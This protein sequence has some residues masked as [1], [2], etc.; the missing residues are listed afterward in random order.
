MADFAGFDMPIQYSGIVAEHRAVRSTAGIFDVSHMGEFR[1]RGIE[2]L[3]FLQTVL[4]NDLSRLVDGGAL[5]TVMCTEKGGIVDDL[6]VYRV[7]PDDYLLVVNAAN[8]GSDL[9][10]LRMHIAGRNVEVEDI[11]EG[12]ALIAVQGPASIPIVQRIT[13]EPVS[14]LEAFRFLSAAP[15][16]FFSCREAVIART[17]YTGESGVEI[18][19]DAERA[20]DV[21]DALMDAGDRDGLVAAGLGAR[22]TLRLEA[23]YC[24]Y[25]N[26]ITVDTN[27][28]EAGLGW[29]TKLDK[30][31]FVGSTALR[32]IK[33]RGPRRKLIG[34]RMLDRGI[35]RGGYRLLAPAGD[36][37]GNVTSGSQSPILGVGI[38]LGYVVNRPEHVA[39]G[40][41]ISVEVRGK[42]L[43]AEVVKPPFHKL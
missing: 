19:C 29:I 9:E 4:S 12:T 10:W 26:D 7:S 18:Y 24:L 43:A 20:A 42:A 15:G 41:R 21:W 38:G 1:V 11:S 39:S 5:Y 17:G 36:H 28:F 32:V 40:S 16:S 2:A 33:E 31:E 23:G 13:S 25:G 30:G 35:P 14:K 3:G 27:P 6:L 34:F 8:V 37:I 22:D